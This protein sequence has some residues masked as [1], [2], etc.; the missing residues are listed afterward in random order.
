MNSFGCR[1]YTVR[2]E[3]CG[4][5]I[6][7][8]LL[9]PVIERLD[10]AFVLAI[11]PHVKP[12]NTVYQFGQFQHTYTVSAS[13]KE[14]QPEDPQT[15]STRL[16]IPPRKTTTKKGKGRYT[17]PVVLLKWYTIHSYVPTKVQTIK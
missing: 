13:L 15:T 2:I 7:L 17:V 5:A 9:L 3:A 14:L 16:P 10:F 12:W 6:G 11:C 4:C 1:F 8:S